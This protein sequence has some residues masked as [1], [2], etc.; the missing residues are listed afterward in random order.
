MSFPEMISNYFTKICKK[1]KVYVLNI[2]FKS[3]TSFQHAQQTQRQ[4]HIITC[5]SFLLH[6]SN[7]TKVLFFVHFF[8]LKN[9]TNH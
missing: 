8:S 6:K 1:C 7:F 5:F 4:M 3:V 2:S 9:L